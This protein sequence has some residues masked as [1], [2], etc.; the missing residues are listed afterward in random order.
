MPNSEELDQNQ[1]NEMMY[2]V[3]EQYIINTEKFVLLCF[4]TMGLYG[5]WWIYKSWR[6]FK[7][8]EMTDIMP[9]AR[10]LLSIL[11]LNFL[12]MKIYDYSKE[13]GYNPRFNSY[14]LYIGFFIVNVLSYLPDPYWMVSNLAF[15]FLIPP[16]KALNYAKENTEGLLITEQPTFNGRQIALILVGTLLW[17]LIILAMVFGEEELQY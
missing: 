2:Y 6:F 14:A 8:K 7:Q 5:I 3:E 12:F 15:L 13:K 17:G 9:A 10:S 11:Y 16:F 1:D 4:I